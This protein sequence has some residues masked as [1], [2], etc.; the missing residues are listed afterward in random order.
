MRKVIEFFILICF[1]SGCATPTFKTVQSEGGLLFKKILVLPFTALS[2][3]HRRLAFDT[4]Y[5]ELATFKDINIVAKENVNDQ[6]LGTL[7]LGNRND[8]D[9][10]DFMGSIPG[11]G[12]LQKAKELFGMNAIVLGAVVVEQNRIIFFVEMVDADRSNITLSF[13]RDAEI[14]GGEVSE[15]I[16]S[17]AHDCAH[18]V[19]SHIQ[20]NVVVTYIH[21]Y[22]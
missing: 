15:I 20:E 16:K 22:L 10:S 21:K 11:E 5:D 14:A 12:R 18:K 8:Y 1:L 3:E 9:A 2:P 13:S 7:Q 17:L 6:L 4:F 19:I